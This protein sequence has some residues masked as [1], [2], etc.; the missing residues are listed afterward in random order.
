[1]H[2]L[3]RECFS[4]TSFKFLDCSSKAKV[5]NEIS[6]PLEIQTCNFITKMHLL[7]HEYKRKKNSFLTIIPRHGTQLLF[8]ISQYQVSTQNYFQD[9]LLGQSNERRQR[10]VRGRE[11]N[12]IIFTL[13]TDAGSRLQSGARS[14]ARQRMWRDR[15]CATVPHTCGSGT[16]DSCS[17]EGKSVPQTIVY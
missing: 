14:R 10:K 17:P 13:T 16:D 2:P 5:H 15:R 8:E 9:V 3:Q 7:F 1:M 11:N 6:L 12:M 4:L